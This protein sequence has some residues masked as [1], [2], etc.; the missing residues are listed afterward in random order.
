MAS[1]ADATGVADP[2]E[3]ALQRRR[4]R[5]SAPWTAADRDELARFNTDLGNPSGARAVGLLEN[6]ETVCVMTGQQAGL[7]TGPLYTLYKALGALALAEGL[8]RRWGGR[9]GGE[10]VPVVAA[11]WIASDDHDYEEVAQ[12]AWPDRDGLPRRQMVACRTGAGNTSVHSIPLKN[13]ELEPLFQTIA[14]TCHGG[15]RLMATLDDLRALA[16]VS[17]TVE[18]FFARCLL[19]LVGPD[20]GLILVSPRLAALRRVQKTV[21]AREFSHPGVS[22]NQV[23]AAGQALE[24]AGHKA[25]L[26]RRPTDINAFVYEPRPAP[27]SDGPACPPI[28]GR[29]LFADGAFVSHDPVDG[30]QLA[31]RS[32]AE[33]ERLLAAAPERFSANV[34]TRPLVQDARFPTVA[35]VGGPGEVAYLAQMASLYDDFAVAAPA[36]IA[37]PGTTLVLPEVARDLERLALSA[38]AFVRQGEEQIWADVL[39]A[40][41]DALL[42]TIADTAAQVDALLA[43]LSDGLADQAPVARN[44]RKLRG[45]IERGFGALRRRTIRHLAARDCPLRDRIVRVGQALRPD[46]NEQERTFNPFVPFFARYGPS[47][48]DLLATRFADGPVAGAPGGPPF[49]SQA[50]LE[51]EP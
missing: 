39:D 11:F 25:P 47:L 24:T 38:E 37:R 20:S 33:M 26:F 10:A 18:D 42:G 36:V 8:R 29:L 31:V 35:Y 46:G 17:E 12:V 15:D 2:L 44:A 16:A 27:G 23:I 43:S 51:I 34:V 4:A 22:S 32:P 6:P 28:R 45:K 3:E 1:M 50:F 49:A 30:A 40:R 14:R 41:D 48:V 5:P 21:L 13:L 9:T 7:L 19:R